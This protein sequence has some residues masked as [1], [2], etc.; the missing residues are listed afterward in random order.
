[1]RDTLNA[2]LRW[3]GDQG[4]DPALV[5]SAAIVL[6]AS[7][8]IGAVV[9]FL[10]RRVARRHRAGLLVSV[11]THTAGA[12]R[13]FVVAFGF[14]LWLSTDGTSWQALRLP[15]RI[16]TI[17]VGGW[18]AIGVVRGGI[19]Y[20]LD[21]YDISQADNLEA[22]RMLT[23]IRLLGRVAGWA[24]ALATAAGMLMAIP[25]IRNIGVSLFA[26]AGIAGLAVGLAA[27]PVLSNMLAG[28]QIALTQPIRIDDVVIVEGEWGRV[29]E[30]NLTF[31]VVRIWDLRRLVLPISYF[32]ERPFQN[33][34]RTSARIVGSV[35]IHAD[36]TLPI[37]DVRAEFGR[38]LR[39]SKHWDGDVEVVQVT[40]STD[41]TMEIRLLMSAENSGIAWDLR[42]EIREHMIAYL[43]REHA[44]ALPKVRLEPNRGG[45]PVPGGGGVR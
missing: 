31:V 39:A 9:E 4:L 22:R 44:D 45:P 19:A 10:V 37:D 15:T 5:T 23:Q 25:G 36:F 43:Q 3:L 18:F 27:R 34:T 24:I 33:W 42:C 2:A 16:L 40:D 28:I 8:A 41:R 17:A 14:L 20:A 13:V 12:F 32:I 21:K 1:M 6:S 11:A 35:F 38:A 26:S 7:I 29:E 30:I